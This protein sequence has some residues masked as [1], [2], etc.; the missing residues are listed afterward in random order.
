MKIF[1]D[2]LSELKRY[3]KIYFYLLVT[4]HA[5]QML[6]NHPADSLTVKNIQEYFTRRLP[7]HFRKTI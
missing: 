1:F 6:K 4:L 7:N 5:K 2:S 3:E